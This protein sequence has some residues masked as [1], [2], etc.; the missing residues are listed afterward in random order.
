MPNHITN[1]VTASKEVIH[2]LLN[3]GGVDFSRIIPPPDTENYKKEACDHGYSDHNHPQDCWLPWRTKHWGTK[4]NAY[5]TE[6]DEGDL[7]VT[8]ETAWSSP[9]PV[10]VTLSKL[11]PTEP[12][13]VE[14][15]SEDTGGQV[16]MYCLLDGKRVLEHLPTE[17]SRE[18]MDMAS[19]IRYGMTYE[20]S[21]LEQYGDEADEDYQEALAR[22]RAS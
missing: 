11:F 6:L 7:G 3:E 22:F 21:L 2:A 14:Y 15:A 4:W 5:E 9:E 8:F 13:D 18:A 17:Y 10:L 20:E 1:H 12:I 19:E 16:G